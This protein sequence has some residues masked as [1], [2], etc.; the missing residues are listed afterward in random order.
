MSSRD[1]VN[2]KALTAEYADQFSKEGKTASKGKSRK[3]KLKVRTSG[4]V[5]VTEADGQSKDPFSKPSP[6]LIK[7]LAA[8]SRYDAKRRRFSDD[9]AGPSDEQR[10]AIME[11]K[12][13]KYDRIRKGDLRGM[14]EKEIKEA[15]LDVCPHLR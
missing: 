3:H 5:S 10:R 9:D 13:A 14:T 6:G 1:I 2:L 8:E 7:R 12:A 4:P 15:A 11:A